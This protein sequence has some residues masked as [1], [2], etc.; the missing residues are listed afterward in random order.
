MEREIDSD[1]DKLVSCVRDVVSVRIAMRLLFMHVAVCARLH[2][3]N[4][5]S[6]LF[7]WFGVWRG[8]R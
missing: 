5:L 3:I 6:C 4:I 7:G 2:V 8:R 1:R